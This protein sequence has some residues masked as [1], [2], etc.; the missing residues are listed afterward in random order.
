MSPATRI[1]RSYL[2][3][4]LFTLAVLCAAVRADGGVVRL[5][6]GYRPS[7]RAGNEQS[8]EQTC[9]Y[10]RKLDDVIDSN[11]EQC[12]IAYNNRPDGE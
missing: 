3:L 7:D 8:S 6:N 11:N 10:F 5:E 12:M 1:Q 4:Y 2:H 9:A